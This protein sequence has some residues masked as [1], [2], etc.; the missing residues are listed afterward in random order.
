MKCEKCK[1]TKAKTNLCGALLCVSCFNNWKES[2][3]TIEEFMKD[4]K[5]N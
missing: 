5:D 1:R 4:E 2:N 3:Q